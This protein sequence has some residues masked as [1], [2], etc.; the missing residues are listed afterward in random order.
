MNRSIAFATMMV[1]C[2]HAL[3]I[4]Q[5]ADSSSASSSSSSSSSSAS[6]S[7]GLK[8]GWDEFG[9]PTYKSGAKL[10]VTFEKPGWA[11]ATIEGQKS[12][13]RQEVVE[14]VLA[15]VAHRISNIETVFSVLKRFPAHCTCCLGEAKGS[16]TTGSFEQHDIDNKSPDGEFIAERYEE[17][18]F[19]FFRDNQPQLSACFRNDGTSDALTDLILKSED[20]GDVSLTAQNQ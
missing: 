3:G 7:S 13:P 5:T 19:G 18:D 2:A 16:W 6:A 4:A 11:I 10:D 17:K 20:A 12:A 8:F 15:D 14:E 1:A 9:N